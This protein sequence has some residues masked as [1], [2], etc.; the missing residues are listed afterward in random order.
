MKLFELGEG[1]ADKD[2][3]E[4][5]EVPL[6]VD[7]LREGVRQV[8]LLQVLKIRENPNRKKRLIFIFCLWLFSFVFYIVKNRKYW[9]TSGT[10]VRKSAKYS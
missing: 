6:R 2:I 3:L 9:R 5:G 7:L 4:A 1:G 10:T 8:E